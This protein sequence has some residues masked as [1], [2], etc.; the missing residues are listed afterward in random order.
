VAATDIVMTLPGTT[1]CAE[2]RVGARPVL[3]LD[4]MPGGPVDDGSIGT[5][6]GEVVGAARASRLGSG[7]GARRRAKQET[8]TC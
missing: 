1:T 5:V 7:R 8:G 2:V 4:R 6:M 3:L